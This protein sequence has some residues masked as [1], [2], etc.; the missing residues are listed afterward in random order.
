MLKA[1]HKFMWSFTKSF[2]R[3][4]KRPVFIY[5][6]TLAITLQL[7]FASVF[8]EVESE[9]NQMAKSFFDC[10]YYTVSVMTGV[11]L[12]DVHP[13]TTL[14]RVTSIFMMLSGTVIFVSFT[15]ALAASILQVESQH[16]Q[17]N[18]R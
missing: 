7:F 17:R 11:G 10:L 13:I 15:G 3:G 6:M 2:L 4:L 9:S 1:H 5:L 16:L 12:G 8:Y 18:D 14:G